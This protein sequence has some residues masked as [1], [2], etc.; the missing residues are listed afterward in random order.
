[1]NTKAIREGR[2]AHTRFQAATKKL[3]SISGEWLATRLEI[4]RANSAGNETRRGPKRKAR[5]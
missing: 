2:Q 1:M 5:V 3:L 4:H